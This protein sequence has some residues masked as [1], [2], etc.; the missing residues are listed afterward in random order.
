MGN[1]EKKENKCCSREDFREFA[2]SLTK[3]ELLAILEE[4]KLEGE[5][6]ICKTKYVLEKEELQEII[7]N[8]ADDS[9]S[10][11]GYGC[12]GCCSGGCSTCH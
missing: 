2:E 11:C 5:C 6:D 8:K 3:H 7:D 1:N 12:S 4:G 9:E 10:G